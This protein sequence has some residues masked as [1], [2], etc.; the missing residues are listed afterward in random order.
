[1]PTGDPNIPADVLRAKKLYEEVNLGSSSYSTLFRAQRA[2]VRGDA[3]EE[4]PII[5]VDDEDLVVIDDD[6][7]FPNDNL[8]EEDAF[9]DASEGKEGPDAGVLDLYLKLFQLRNNPL[10]LAR[11]SREEE[12]VLTELLQLLKELNCPLKAFE[13]IL[14]WA[15]KSN[16]SGHSFCKGCQPTHSKQGNCLFVQKVQHERID[17]KGEEAVP[18][19]H[20]ENSV[21]DLL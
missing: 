16:G 10:G 12:E 6:D 11:F 13:I 1:M 2:T 9:T 17:P 21:H 7:G 15:A 19:L 8:D 4:P 14:K 3:D 5:N 18:A 20:T